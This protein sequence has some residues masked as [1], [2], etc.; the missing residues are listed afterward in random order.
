MHLEDGPRALI[1]NTKVAEGDDVDG[2]KVVS[3]TDD[4][5]VLRKQNAEI[6][7]RLK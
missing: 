5:V 1:N 3:I 7:L 6:K 4:T 2:A